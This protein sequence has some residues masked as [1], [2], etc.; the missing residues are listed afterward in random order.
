MLFILSLDLTLCSEW[1]SLKTWERIYKIAV[2]SFFFILSVWASILTFVIN[3]SWKGVKEKPRVIKSL[4]NENLEYLS[5]FMSYLLPLIGYDTDDP[6]R[7]VL[8]II[9]ILLFALLFMKTGIYYKNPVLAILGYKLYNAQIEDVEAEDGVI[10]LSK[11]DLKASSNV[12]YIM[13]DEHIWIAK[14]VR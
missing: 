2:P 10:L 11:D 4:H 14:E 13:L 5:F 12:K 1:D 8:T 6:R 3:I 7:L 9:L